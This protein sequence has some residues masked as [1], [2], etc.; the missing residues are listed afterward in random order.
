MMTWAIYE[1]LQSHNQEMAENLLAPEENLDFSEACL[2]EA[3]R[4]YSVV[5]TV[6]RGATKDIKLDNNV[7][8]PK[9]STIMINIQAVHHDDK[10]WGENAAVRYDPFRF[11]PPPKSL[12][13]DCSKSLNRNGKVAPFTFLPFIDGPR[14]CLGQHLALLESKIVLSQLMRRYKFELVESNNDSNFDPRHKYMVPVIPAE[15]LQVKVN[16]RT[17]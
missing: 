16:R 2:R 9:G 6:T 17:R 3:L 1:L 15:G 11:I 5:P 8:I 4:K 14:N 10:I 13:T 7:V 12:E